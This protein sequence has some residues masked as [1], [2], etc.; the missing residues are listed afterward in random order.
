MKITA[1]FQ[2]LMEEIHGFVLSHLHTAGQ[3]P[4]EV[5]V[6]VSDLLLCQIVGFGKLQKLLHVAVP[7]SENHLPIARNSYFNVFPDLRNWSLRVVTEWL[8]LRRPHERHFFYHCL[9]SLM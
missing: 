5:G 8:Q 2:S 4:C 6:N 1:H 9:L 3:S 7:L